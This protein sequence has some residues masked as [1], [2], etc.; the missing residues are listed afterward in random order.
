ML[1][2]K[3]L[4]RMLRLWMT[5]NFSGL[6]VNRLVD[7]LGDSEGREGN[8]EDSRGKHFDGCVEVFGVKRNRVSKADE[9]W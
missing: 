6:L 5:Y 2:E 1:V 8:S 9:M 3:Q 7:I 4:G